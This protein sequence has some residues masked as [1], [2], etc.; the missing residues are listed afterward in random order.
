MKTNIFSLRSQILINKT[1]NL[2]Q[3]DIDVCKH[4]TKEQ[5]IKQ[6]YLSITTALFILKLFELMLQFSDL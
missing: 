4:D 2:S 5:R 3:I 1:K 6:F